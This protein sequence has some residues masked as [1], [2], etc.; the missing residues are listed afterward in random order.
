MIAFYDYRRRGCLP[1]CL[2]ALLPLSFF[3]DHRLHFNPSVAR[4]AADDDDAGGDLPL[5]CRVGALVHNRC[6]LALPH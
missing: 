3:P 2:L 4:A 1:A 5:R 6:G